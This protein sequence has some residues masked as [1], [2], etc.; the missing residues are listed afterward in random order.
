MPVRIFILPDI[1]DTS[2]ELIPDD[3]L[4]QREEVLETLEQF[5]VKESRLV[6]EFDFLIYDFDMFLELSIPCSEGCFRN[7]YGKDDIIVL[8]IRGQY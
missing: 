7:M 2:N 6:E 8:M 3:A 4:L 5:E 1:S